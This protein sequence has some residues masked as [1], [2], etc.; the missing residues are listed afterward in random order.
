M[1]LCLQVCHLVCGENQL[2]L[3]LAL[4]IRAHDIQNIKYAKL[5]KIKRS[6]ISTRVLY[7][8]FLYWKFEENFQIFN[9]IS[10]I[11]T[12]RTQFSKKIPIWGFLNDYI[13]VRKNHW[14]APLVIYLSYFYN[15]KW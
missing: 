8:N 4:Q 5:T 3:K 7:L 1:V 12:L 2:V 9:K 6:L 13:F 14:L 10:Q 15:G 11:Y